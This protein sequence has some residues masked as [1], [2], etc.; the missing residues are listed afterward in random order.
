MEQIFSQVGLFLSDINRRRIESLESCLYERGLS[1]CESVNKIFT[2]GSHE[3]SLHIPLFTT[4]LEPI[5][6]YNLEY[7]GIKDIKTTIIH[8]P[9]DNNKFQCCLQVRGAWVPGFENC[10][11]VLQSVVSNIPIIEY[12]SSRQMSSSL[13]TEKLEIKLAWAGGNLYHFHPVT[14]VRQKAFPAIFDRLFSTTT[15]RGDSPIM[16]TFIDQRG[17]LMEF[18]GRNITQLPLSPRYSD[19]ERRE[20]ILR[21][22]PL[23]SSNNDNASD[24]QSSRGRNDHDFRGHGPGGND[25]GR[26]PD[27]GG[28]GQGRGPGASV[29]QPPAQPP[30]NN[31]PIPPNNQP[32]NNNNINNAST[33]RQSDNRHNNLFSQQL[34]HSQQSAP[35]RTRPGNTGVSGRTG[36]AI[37]QH[38]A[39]AR[40][41]VDRQTRSAIEPGSGPGNLPG[42]AELPGSG[43]GP[44]VNATG[45]GSQIL[46]RSRN[47]VHISDPPGS[48][49]G[50]EST[51]SVFDNND[52]ND[53]DDNGGHGGGS[54][55]LPEQEHVL[56]PPGGGRIEDVQLG[57]DGRGEIEIDNDSLHSAG[58]LSRRRDVSESSHNSQILPSD[59]HTSTPIN[60][61]RNSNPEQGNNGR[62]SRHEFNGETNAVSVQPIPAFQPPGIP[63]VR[64]PLPP[65]Q[66]VYQSSAIRPHSQNNNSRLLVSHAESGS[67]LHPSR[68]E[69]SRQ[70]PGNR[71]RPEGQSPG[72]RSG[73]DTGNVDG[74][75]ASDGSGRLTHHSSL[76]HTGGERSPLADQGTFSHHSEGS[77]VHQPGHRDEE[78]SVQGREGAGGDDPRD[79]RSEKSHERTRAHSS[80]QLPP[81]Q[82]GADEQGSVGG[83]RH[84]ERQ[85]LSDGDGEVPR[86]EDRARADLSQAVGRRG[87]QSTGD[88]DLG[89][90]NSKVS[91]DRAENQDNSLHSSHRLQDQVSRLAA[92]GETS[93]HQ[94]SGAITRGSKGGGRANNSSSG[95]TGQE[96]LRDSSRLGVPRDPPG[97]PPAKVRPGKGGSESNQG[98]KGSRNGEGDTSSNHSVESVMKQSVVSQKKTKK[99]KKNKSQSNS[100]TINSTTDNTVT[101]RIDESNSASTVEHISIGAGSGSEGVISP[102]SFQVPES[103]SDNLSQILSN[104]SDQE[105]GRIQKELDA[106]L[107]TRN[108]A[109]DVH[110]K[111]RLAHLDVQNV[112][113]D[114]IGGAV[115]MD[116]AYL[117]LQTLINNM[118]TLRARMV[119]YRLGTNITLAFNNAVDEV[120]RTA[121]QARRS[122]E[123]SAAA[124]AAAERQDAAARALEAR[125]VEQE[126][127]LYQE[128][129]RQQEELHQEE[130]RVAREQ[131]E[132]RLTE[133]R[134]S[135]SDLRTIA[136]ANSI[137]QSRQSLNRVDDQ[138]F[139]YG[140][141][142]EDILAS[143]SQDNYR[144]I[145]ATGLTPGAVNWS[146]SRLDDGEQADLTFSG[147]HNRQTGPGLVN[148][149]VNTHTTVQVYN[150]DVQAGA[151]QGAGSS[152]LHNTSQLP[153]TPLHP[154]NL[155]QHSTPSHGTTPL[156]NPQ[157]LNVSAD[158]FGDS[159]LS[160]PPQSP[161]TL[162][163]ELLAASERQPDLAHESLSALGLVPPEGSPLVASNAIVTPGTGV[164]ESVFVDSPQSA[165]EIEEG[166]PRPE[167]NIGKS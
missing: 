154:R 36:S 107:E 55:V 14:N 19:D 34:H 28:G 35:P 39:N 123:E 129:M 86:P 131:Y 26:G 128:Q 59:V 155:L 157:S 69:T 151:E 122:F 148:D 108:R 65:L 75:N 9:T 94:T 114:M 136:I 143:S 72:D 76:H 144:L 92:G 105:R 103:P 139:N 18:Q 118:N 97:P 66:G 85:A 73:A 130:M 13:A 100:T 64:P 62:V 50:S 117:Q 80:R 17:S 6:L 152:T 3:Y 125:R 74:R 24:G 32:I 11:L 67:V 60:N 149:S 78:I 37:L 126:M 159:L 167:Q 40:S 83:R 91:R 93:H 77:R 79:E 95:Q 166:E 46:Q 147:Q 23:V 98:G 43:P 127:D 58:D 146:G 102:N 96:D 116:G 31:P 87:L 133:V 51:H 162:D 12:E 84:R 42:T 104:G 57:L 27:G 132:R 29:Q 21:L 38:E 71:D 164:S 22:R 99:S 119:Q 88:Q 163:Q 90:G 113:E 110:E 106:D 49:R 68:T 158:I 61:S 141:R 81:G 1:V 15:I 150:A 20:A 165:D 137:R 25:N 112:V 134:S 156:Q 89:G 16:T 161:L 153:A 8:I 45:Q 44:A 121:N 120:I 56:Q 115:S 142:A 52:D 82:V 160:A 138:E 109:A 111:L 135:T 30:P 33:A 4:L 47:S 124:N 10:R 41:R 53:N 63:T 7:F 101:R 145:G 70:L 54:I 48:L 2:G 5:D 140:P